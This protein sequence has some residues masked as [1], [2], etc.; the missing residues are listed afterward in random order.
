MSATASIFVGG[1]IA[2]ALHQAG[3]AGARNLRAR[4]IPVERRKLDRRVIDDFNRDAALAEQ[5]HGPEE[6]VVGDADHQFERA[7]L[8]YHFLDDEAVESRLGP[9]R[10][11]PRRHRRRRA[12]HSFRRREA[13]RDAAD[14]A[15]MRDVGRIN[16]ERDRSLDRGRDGRGIVRVLRDPGR[17]EWNAVGREQRRYFLRLKPLAPGAER[18]GQERGGAGPVVRHSLGV[19]RHGLQQQ[20]LI[21]PVIDAIHETADRRVGRIVAGDMRI[22]EQLARGRRGII[23]DPVGEDVTSGKAQPFSGHRVDNGAGRVD[24]RLHRGWT[25]DHED[26]VDIAVLEHCLQRGSIARRVGVAD[27][28]DWIAVTPG[29]GKTSIE[30]GHRRRRQGRQDAAVLD[31]RIGREHGRAAAVGQDGEAVASLRL[32]GRQR[33]RRFEQLGHVANPQHAGATESGVIDLVRAGERAGMR[34]CGFLALR[35]AAHLD[36]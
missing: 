6:H 24:R 20:I 31:Q 22:G 15:L 18:A 2:I 34:G 19:R 25:I 32:R 3:N 14:I 13:E 33:L 11:Y 23:A 16:L 1:L 27:H 21:A 5:D 26:G 9:C 36:H 4:Q 8:R 29:A 17:N 7:R 35:K 10:L 30:L 12:P 28:V